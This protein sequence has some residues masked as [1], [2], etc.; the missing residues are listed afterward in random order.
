M[1]YLAKVNSTNVQS[2]KPA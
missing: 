2:Y 1:P